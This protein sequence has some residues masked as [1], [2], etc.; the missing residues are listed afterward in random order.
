[1]RVCSPPTS[2][3][4]FERCI[5]Y[6]FHA[7]ID[8]ARHNPR[9]FFRISDSYSCWKNLAQSK[10][11]SSFHRFLQDVT[12]ASAVLHIEHLKP[13]FPSMEASSDQYHLLKH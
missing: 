12:I 6:I 8:K 3:L 11:S 1:M 2:L 4:D 9:L 10:C 7:F 5:T 13:G